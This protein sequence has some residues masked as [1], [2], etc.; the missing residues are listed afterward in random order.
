MK[1]LLRNIETIE[2]RLKK[3]IARVFRHRTFPELLRSLVSISLILTVF[4]VV[5]FI[6]VAVRAMNIE[7][8]FWRVLLIVAIG[9]F[10]VAFF[11]YYFVYRG[12]GCQ[13]GIIRR[14]PK[15][16]IVSLTFD[17]GPSPDYT[18]LIL[19]ILK[20]KGVRATFFLVGKHAEKYPDI[21]KRIVEE[22]HE[23]GN[24]TYSHKDLAPATPRRVMNEIKRGMEAISR[25]TGKEQP[26][27]FRPPRGI[28]SGLVR[29]IV[30]EMDCKMILWSLSALDWAGTPSSVIAARIRK[31]VHPGAIILFHDNGALIRSEGHS[32][33]N[34]VKAIPAV[35]EYLRAEGYEFLTVGKMLALE[36]KENAKKE[37][38]AISK[39]RA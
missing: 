31:F 33:M 8:V 14:G 35:I 28:Y 9:L 23:V 6:L 1:Q 19:D 24:H 20:D 38:I 27:L 7:V 32:R 10:L 30:V 12:F 17:D 29:K 15:L 16:P 36:R 2:Y 25:V 13:Q 21:V 34:T 3:T 39:A 26:V 37:D 18:P 5:R 22:G 11:I 4:V